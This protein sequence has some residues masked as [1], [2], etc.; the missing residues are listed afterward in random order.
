MY[1]SIEMS[2]YIKFKDVSL[3]L[4][5]VRLQEKSNDDGDETQYLGKSQTKISN[6]LNREIIYI[7]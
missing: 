3:V 1:C 2:I 6:I 5:K 4:R 7:R